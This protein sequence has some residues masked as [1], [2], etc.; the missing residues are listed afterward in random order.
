MDAFFYAV[1]NKEQISATLKKI[2]S[3]KNFLPFF[4]C[5]LWVISPKIEA[6]NPITKAVD[7][8]SFFIAFKIKSIP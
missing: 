2:K 6:I 5:S 1:L 7:M 3:L 8:V 4:N